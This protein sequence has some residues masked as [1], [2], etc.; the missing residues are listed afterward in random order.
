MEHGR[1]IRAV[2]S[3][4]Q[5]QPQRFAL[6]VAMLLALA[7]GTLD[8]LPVERMTSFRAALADA[9]EDRPAAVAR[10]GNTGQLDD[11]CRTDLRQLIELAA[12]PASPPEAEAAHV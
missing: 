12:G 4:V 7:D 9:L 3:Q 2:L 6:Q 8:R 10:L 1:R 11:T 5:M